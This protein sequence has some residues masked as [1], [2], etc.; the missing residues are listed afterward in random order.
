MSSQVLSCDKSWA[1][2]AWIYTRNSA[3]LAHILVF[4]HFT[5]MQL[6]TTSELTQTHLTAIWS[7]AIELNTVL[8][9]LVTVRIH[10][11]LTKASV[12]NRKTVH[13]QMAFC[14]LCFTTNFFIYIQAGFYL[15]SI[16]GRFRRRSIDW[17]RHMTSVPN[18][19]QHG[20]RQLLLLEFFLTKYPSLLT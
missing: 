9:M 4:F 10:D 12:S 18:E 8:T 13:V 1:A 14:L 5:S 20:G 17:Q 11:L 16:S 2:I 3:L 15:L 7:V 19:N 6:S